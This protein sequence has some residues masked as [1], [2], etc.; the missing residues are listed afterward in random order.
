MRLHGYIAITIALS[1]VSVTHAAFLAKR[2]NLPNWLVFSLVQGWSG[3]E[4]VDLV[5]TRLTTYIT[6][7]I[8]CIARS[9]AATTSCAFSDISCLC[10]TDFFFA[11]A[12]TCL[13]S[14]CSSANQ[15][16]GIQAGANVGF[17]FTCSHSPVPQTSFQSLIAPNLTL[18]HFSAVLRDSIARHE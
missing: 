6:S 8:V 13:A 17:R 3:L 1:Y 14:S 2:N 11:T 7:V 15:V 4:I 12:E 9:A 16:T 5:L 18:P 10:K